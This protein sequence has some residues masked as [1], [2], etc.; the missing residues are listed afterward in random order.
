MEFHPD[1]TSRTVEL[2][3][4][5][6]R[7]HAVA[8]QK[9]G[10]ITD[11]WYRQDETLK[12]AITRTADGEVRRH[13]YV[14]PDGLTYKLDTEF[15]PGGQ[16]KKIRELLDDHTTRLRFFFANGI[17]NKDQ[18]ILLREKGWVMV[19]EDVRREDDSLEQTFRLA[20]DGS[21]LT[22]RFSPTGVLTAHMEKNKQNTSYTEVWY[23]DDG[24]TLTR[25]LEQTNEGTLITLLDPTGATTETYQFHGDMKKYGSVWRKVYVDGKKVLEQWYELRKDG[26][27]N[28]DLVKTFLPNG[29]EGYLVW[30]ADDGVTVTCEVIYH[31]DQEIKSGRTIKRYREE[32][33]SLKEVEEL[34]GNNKTVSEVQ[35]P[36]GNST[37]VT[38]DPSLTGPMTIEMPP[39]IIPYAPPQMH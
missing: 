32:D 20:D 23:L 27:I 36:E 3:P 8:Q 34:D 28:L 7:Q 5:G 19:S 4:S 18:S 37:K 22:E 31:G 25:K 10:L 24:K 15:Y 35:Y 26:S 9:D 11:Y 29:K 12:E 13:A 16:T 30:F 33:G 39:F 21:M 1:E 17:V 6:A 14:Q 38:A 2:Y